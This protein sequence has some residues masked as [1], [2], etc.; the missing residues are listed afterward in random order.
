MYDRISGA[1]LGPWTLHWVC[2]ALLV[3]HFLGD[4]ASWRWDCMIG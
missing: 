3:M 1:S 2:E 4:G